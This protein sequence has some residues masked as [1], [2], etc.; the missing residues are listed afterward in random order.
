MELNLRAA[1]E[2]L[3]RPSEEVLETMQAASREAQEAVASIAPGGSQLA[4]LSSSGDEASAGVKSNGSAVDPA[5]MDGQQEASD[6]S[7]LQVVD[8][9]G[10][11][12]NA[13]QV[14]SY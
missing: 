9:V 7:R 13:E 1:Q 2:Q 5:K 14:H 10:C 11:R 8:E 6:T 4:S 12:V 3:A